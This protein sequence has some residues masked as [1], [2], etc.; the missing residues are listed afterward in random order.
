MFNENHPQVQS[1]LAG[2]QLKINIEWKARFPNLNVPTL[3]IEPGQRYLRIVKQ[4]ASSRSAWAFIDQ[5]TGDVLKA[6]SWSA[7]AKIARGNLAD[8]SN[9]LARMTAW[10]PVYLR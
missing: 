3:A 6:A 8:A 9:G 1:W 10:G 4:D 2:C 5:Y 7:P